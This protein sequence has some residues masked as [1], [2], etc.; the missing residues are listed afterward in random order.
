M[1]YFKY[2]AE[3]NIYYA[4]T[5]YYGNFYLIK[6]SDKVSFANPCYK[7]LGDNC[8]LYPTSL[9]FTLDYPRNLCKMDW[10]TVPCIFFFPPFDDID[11]ICPLTFVWY[12]HEILLCHLRLLRDER[13]LW[14]KDNTGISLLQIC[15]HLSTLCLSEM[16]AEE[17][18]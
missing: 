16:V 10:F 3:T 12:T 14:K 9:S 17:S 18:V 1:G 2:F 7:N 5:I 15:I 13:F 6:K 8:I 11:N 4:Y